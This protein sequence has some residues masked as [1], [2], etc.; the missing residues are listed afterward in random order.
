[1]YLLNQLVPDVKGQSFQVSAVN[2]CTQRYWSDL[3]L[4]QEKNIKSDDNTVGIIHSQTAFLT[5]PE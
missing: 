4:K 1:M 3:F 2:I 5:H